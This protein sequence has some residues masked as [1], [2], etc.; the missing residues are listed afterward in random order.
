[1]CLYHCHIKVFSWSTTEKIEIGHKAFSP[2]FL[3][4]MGKKRADLQLTFLYISSKKKFQHQI[5]LKTM[6]NGTHKNQIFTVYQ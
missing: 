2:F 4:G 6:S 1:M 3:S 5:I